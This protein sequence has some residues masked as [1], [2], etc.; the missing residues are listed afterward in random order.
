M[1]AII[2]AAGRSE[3]LDSEIN[4]GNKCLLLFNEKPILQRSLDYAISANV[5]EIIIVVGYKA[6]EIINRY[7]LKYNRTSIKYVFQNE[8]HG[9]VNA[10]EL[11]KKYVDEDF[12]LLLGDELLLNPN[13]R[14][15]GQYFNTKNNVFVLCGV[16]PVKDKQ[17]ITKNYS[18]IISN[19]SIHRLVEKP[20]YVFN[21][22]MGTG[23]CFFRREIFDYI[24]L[25]PISTRRGRNEKEL[26]DLIQYAIDEGK[27]V[28]Y[29]KIADEYE[30]INDEESLLNI[31]KTWGNKNV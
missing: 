6:E 14:K 18:I 8:R 26:P 5:K 20:T 19:H 23:N 17:R 24:S 25:V 3:R 21:N 15:M 12:L 2:L 4:S 31:I 16:V 7:G 22:L 13:H 10:I 11:C 9:I 28:E 1:K 27:S 30:N 29:Y